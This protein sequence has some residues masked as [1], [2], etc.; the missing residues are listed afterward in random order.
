MMHAF[1][2]PGLREIEHRGPYMHDGSIA[3][4]EAVIEHYDDGGADRPSRSELIK[5]LGL[6]AGEKS[7]LVAFLKTLTSNP[8]PTMM[9]VLPR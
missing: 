3:T 4:L 6:T 8:I 7:D 9:P 2:T 5:P 1:K